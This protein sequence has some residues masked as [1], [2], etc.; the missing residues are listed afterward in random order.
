MNRVHQ[1]SWLI[2]CFL[3][4]ATTA[5]WSPCEDT[6]VTQKE[7]PDGDFVARFVIRDCGATTDFA[8]W[9]ILERKQLLFS[10]EHLVMVVEGKAEV[11]L[12]WEESKALRVKYKEGRVFR[13]EQRWSNVEITYEPKK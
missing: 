9:V 8:S 4:A 5:C 3:S 11:E 1:L 7:S 10:K 13:M 2:F 6:L 12:A